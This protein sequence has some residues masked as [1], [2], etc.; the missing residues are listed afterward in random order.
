MVG[1]SWT[2]NISGTISNNWSSKFN[3]NSFGGVSVNS[4]NFVTGTPTATQFNYVQDGKRSYLINSFLNYDKSFGKHDLNLMIG[5]EVFES[6]FREAQG[7]AKNGIPSQDLRTSAVA[8]SRDGYNSWEEDS[9]YSQFGR[10]AYSFGNK[11]LLT[12]TFRN[13]ATSKFAPG[14]RQAFFPSLSIGWNIANESFFSVKSINDLK[15]R[16]GAGKLGNA[17]VPSNLWRQEYVM[18]SNGTWNAQ[19][20]VNKYITWEKTSS[21]NVGIDVGVWQNALTATVDFYNKETKD[22]LLNISLP[23]S[24]GFSSYY[25]NKGIIQNRGL[26]VMLGF[27]NSIGKVNFSVNANMAYNQNKVLDLGLANYLPGRSSDGLINNRTFANGPVSAFFGYVAEGLYQSQEEINALNEKAVAAGFSTYDGTVYPG[28]IK[29]KDINGDGRI[30]ADKDQTSIGNPWPKY[31][32]GFNLNFEYVGVDLIMSWQGVADVDIYNGLLKYNQNMFSDWNS[33][34]KVFDVWSPSNT[35]S[36]IPQLGNSTHN[37]G[38]SN[39]YAIEDGSYLR[40]KNIQLGYSLSQ[41]LISKF[42]IQK[43]R[44]YVGMENALTFTKFSGFDPEF[45]TGSNYN[46]GVYGLNQYP[47]SRTIVFGIQLGI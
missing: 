22:A 34:A 17:D 37:Y 12:A 24:S 36:S 45:M 6:D 20:V 10:L 3:F 26:E 1:L 27:K 41:N 18:Q 42:R 4:E 13:D 14:K 46:R 40:L 8:T 21:V 2:T 39:S 32:Y 47:Q 33:T 11:Y 23:T 30:S 38:Q 15:L 29:F 35:T 44:V 9:R 7:F 16:F 19:R 28:D 31:V 25:V 5:T 43:L